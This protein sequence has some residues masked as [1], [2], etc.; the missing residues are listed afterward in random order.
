M[1]R[2]FFGFV[3]REEGGTEILIT[4]GGGWES[5]S[6]YFFVPLESLEVQGNVPGAVRSVPP[7]RIQLCVSEGVLRTRWTPI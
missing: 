4:A 5:R 7:D 2:S 3:I 6:I 1:F